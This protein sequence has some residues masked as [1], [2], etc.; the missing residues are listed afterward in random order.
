MLNF[1]LCAYL[2][3]LKSEEQIKKNTHRYHVCFAQVNLSLIYEEDPQAAISVV[4]MPVVC[5]LCD[6]VGP[7][8]E[9]ASIIV[10]IS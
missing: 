3:K 4:R 1:I 7:S 9:L 5:F 6:N 2:N 8:T 10:T